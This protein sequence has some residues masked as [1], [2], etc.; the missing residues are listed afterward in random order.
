MGVASVIILAAALVL[1]IFGISSRV[2][3]RHARPRG[4]ASEPSRRMG[5]KRVS[6]EPW[7]GTAG[8]EIEA[9]TAQHQEHHHGGM[10]SDHHANH[11]GDSWSGGGDSGGG[12]HHGG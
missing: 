4:S 10:L 5:S 1:V 8:T 6:V 7:D 3:S 12:G 11:H 9:D 2:L